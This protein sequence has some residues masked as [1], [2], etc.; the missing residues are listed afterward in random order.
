MGVWTV[1]REDSGAAG[2]FAVTG[3][4]AFVSSVLLRFLGILKFF[5]L[6]K[7][8]KQSRTGGCFSITCALDAGSGADFFGILALPCD[9]RDSALRLLARFSSPELGVLCFVS[10]G[11]VWEAARTSG[12]LKGFFDP[13]GGAPLLDK[14]AIGSCAEVDTGFGV[15]TGVV[16]VDELGRGFGSRRTTFGADEGLESTVELDDLGG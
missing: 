16:T 12:T 6:A 11:A 9:G 10:C 13:A 1:G 2:G 8:F 15:V 4:S 5:K 14:R 7:L 3:D